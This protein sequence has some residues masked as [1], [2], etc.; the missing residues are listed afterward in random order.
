MR[1]WPG[2]QKNQRVWLLCHKGQQEA[3]GGGA[4]EGETPGENWEPGEEKKKRRRKETCPR[5]ANIGIKENLGKG[6]YKK[7]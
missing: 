3:G 7:H 2:N 6:E 4:Q 5:R 1:W